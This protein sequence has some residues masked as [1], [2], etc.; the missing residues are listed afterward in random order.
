MMIASYSLNV[1]AA[2]HI[3]HHLNTPLH[4][5]DVVVR[6]DLMVVANVVYRW[7]VAYVAAATATAAAWKCQSQRAVVTLEKSAGHHV[8]L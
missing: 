3:Q 1:A 7:Y 5:A 6:S 4:S 8:S 2:Q